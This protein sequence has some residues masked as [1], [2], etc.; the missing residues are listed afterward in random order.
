VKPSSG[1]LAAPTD[2]F[3]LPHDAQRFATSDTYKQTLPAPERGPLPA[4]GSGL[5][6]PVGFRL[7]D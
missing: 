5:I 7:D 4:G 3:T 6:G 2:G 1:P